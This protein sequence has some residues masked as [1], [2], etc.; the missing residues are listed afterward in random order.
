MDK[1][2]ARKTLLDKG[3]NPLI[4]RGNMFV[5]K[6]WG[7]IHLFDTHFSTQENFA[8][9]EHNLK[10]VFDIIELHNSMQKYKKEL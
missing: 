9:T 8:Y 6:D 3:Y 4:E 10:T 7:I 2:A 5:I 1:E